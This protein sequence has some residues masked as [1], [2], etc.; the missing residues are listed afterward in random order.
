MSW[1]ASYID[2][3]MFGD[4]SALMDGFIHIVPTSSIHKHWIAIDCWCDPRLIWS[5]EGG[6]II[7]SHRHLKAPENVYG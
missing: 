7:V 6:T 3:R 1:K 4:M 5:E 2:T